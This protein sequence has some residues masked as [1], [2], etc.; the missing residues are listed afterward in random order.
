[1]NKKVLLYITGNYIE[2]PVINHNF[3]EYMR[4]TES[5][6][7]TAET[8]TTLQIDNTSINFYKDIKWLPMYHFLSKHWTINVFDVIDGDTVLK[9]HL[10]VALSE[11]M[12]QK[13]KILLLSQF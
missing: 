9:T 8:N 3:K 1:M 12:I 5:L 2:Y 4:I 10:S 7:C 11:K 13:N 6:F